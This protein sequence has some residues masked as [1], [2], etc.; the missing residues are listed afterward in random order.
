MSKLN[1][2]KLKYNTY[3]KNKGNNYW[4]ISMRIETF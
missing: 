2:L 1:L 3:R 4:K